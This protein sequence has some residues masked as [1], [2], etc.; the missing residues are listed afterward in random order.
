MRKFLSV[1]MAIAMT[2]G[3]FSGCSTAKNPSN[4]SDNTQT[5]NKEKILKVGIV[6]IVEHPSLDSIRKSFISGLEAKGFTD[7]VNIQ[8][9]YQNAQNDQSNLNSICKKFVGD[10]VDLIVAIATPSA[11]AA[12]A[13]TSEIPVLFSAVTDPVAAKLVIDPNKP[14]ANVTGTSDAIPV[15]KMFELCKELTPNVK[16]IG[17]L[18]TASEVNSKSVIDNAI[19]MID[20]YDLEYEEVAITN[21]SE[22]K[23]AAVSLANKVD[24]IYTPIDNSIA[25]AMPTLAQVG[26]DSKIPIYV[27]ADSLV[28]DGGYATVGI[29]YEDLGVKTAE[30]AA[31]ILSGTPI[32]EIP[33]ATLDNFQKI[34]NKTT[35]IAIDAPSE[36]EGAITIE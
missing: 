14:S 11:Q 20:K 24:A 4:S 22:L 17:F 26:K 13:A 35:A 18:Y 29:N 8:I 23:Q 31:Q 21:T 30:M 5:E 12:A 15:D 6:Q 7:K 16:K 10:K 25:T 36:F 9:D 1:I 32:S 28:A 34:I 2:T 19:A 27:G 3:L 33:V